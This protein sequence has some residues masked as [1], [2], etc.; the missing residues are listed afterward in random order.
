M[1]YLAKA[2]LQASIHAG[3]RPVRYG[4]LARFMGKPMET[5]D[6]SSLPPGTIDHRIGL[7]R[8]SR[9]FAGRE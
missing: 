5:I 3:C 8:R 2:F 9:A 7:F 4:D 6:F 1:R